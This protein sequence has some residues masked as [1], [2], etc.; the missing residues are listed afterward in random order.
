MPAHPFPEGLSAESPIAVG[1]I[2]GY[3][4]SSKVGASEKLEGSFGDTGGGV[5][6]AVA[7]AALRR[8]GTL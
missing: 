7:A 6:V 1:A 3:E 2:V 8:G 5:G 4:P